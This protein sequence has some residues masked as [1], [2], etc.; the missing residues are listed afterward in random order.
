MNGQ[1]LNNKLQ[2]PDEIVKP[3]IN[4]IKIYHN[5]KPDVITQ[6][7]YSTVRLLKVTRNI[8]QLSYQI[9]GYSQ[10]VLIFKI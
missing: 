10:N 2:I 9:K 8:S 6:I 3:G 1:E 4:N 7:V 5:D